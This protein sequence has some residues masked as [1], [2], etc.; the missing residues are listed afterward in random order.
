VEDKNE[1]VLGT[2]CF[3][4]QRKYKAACKKC[5]CKYWIPGTKWQNCSLI[6]A[7]EGTQTLQ[8]IGAIFNVTR[9]RICQIEKTI[10]KKL[11]GKRKLRE[12]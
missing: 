8:E 11:A 2:T 5:T 6:A 3:N 12:H 7:D 10:L 1:I 9:M 4:E